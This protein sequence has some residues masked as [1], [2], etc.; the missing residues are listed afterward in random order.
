MS[1][2]NPWLKFYPTDW[3]SDERLG[4]CS[5]AA[6]GLWMEMIAL[7]H[8]AEPYGHL[9]VNGMKPSD[10]QLAALARTPAD[11]V[12]AVTHELEQAGV[13]SRTRNGTIYSRR[14][15]KDEKKRKDG[16]KCA[17]TG[18]LPDSRRGFQLIEN[19]EEK[20]PPPRVAFPPPHYP[21]ARSQSLEK[22]EKDVRRKRVSYPDKFEM[23]WKAYPTDALMS[24]K[25]AY[26]AWS[27][28]SE[29]DQDICF[30]SVPAFRLKC[31][32]DHQ[33]RPVHLVRYIS[34]RRFD[35]FVE[36]ARKWAARQ[37]AQ[38]SPQDQYADLEIP[39]QLRRTQ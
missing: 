23:L 21:E 35:G 8:R 6:R 24:K 30:E 5:L 36:L 18:T 31:E 10:E 12:R 26:S 1:R 22:K 11:Q 13:F 16:I 33:Y 20:V 25:E 39:Q 32:G 27:K 7:M 2:K 4:M 9:L 29:E 19:K 28:L 38:K 34:Q 37:A 14:M 15:T 17:E 3:Q